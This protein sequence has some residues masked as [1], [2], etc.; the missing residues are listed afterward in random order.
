MYQIFKMFLDF[1][2][3]AGLDIFKQ[4]W[5]LYHIS[6]VIRLEKCCCMA[7]KKKKSCHFWILHS[8]KLKTHDSPRI[9]SKDIYLFEEI[10][11]FNT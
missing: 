7:K 1:K 9:K 5:F 8:M 10:F 6:W 2:K 3:L 4:A 11:S